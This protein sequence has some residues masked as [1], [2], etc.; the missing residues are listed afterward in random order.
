MAYFTHPS[1]GPVWSRQEG[2]HHTPPLPA[3]IM[4]DIVQRNRE[5][6]EHQVQRTGLTPS[7]ECS[8]LT[9]T[10]TAGVCSFCHQ[11]RR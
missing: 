11:P 5:R 1:G 2:Y 9:E 7:C 3:H 6:A 10:D 4:R 8:P